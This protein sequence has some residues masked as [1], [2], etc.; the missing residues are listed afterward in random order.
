[1]G[2]LRMLHRKLCEWQHYVEQA[3][4]TV[5]ISPRQRITEDFF[6]FFKWTHL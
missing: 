6:F 3:T 4:F 2:G 5:P 1:M